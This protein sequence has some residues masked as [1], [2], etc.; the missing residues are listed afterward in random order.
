MTADPMT[1]PSPTPRRRGTLLVVDD[2]REILTALEDLFEED[3]HVHA[4]SSGAEGLDLLH[5][6]P[7]VNGVLDACRE[8]GIT[9]IAYQPLA[10]GVLTGKY[11][12]GEEH[13]LHAD[14]GRYLEARAS[15]QALTL[16]PE[17]AL[18]LFVAP[19][20][21][22]AG[23]RVVAPFMRGYAPSSLPRAHGEPTSLG[24]AVTLLLRP[25]RCTLP[26]GWIGGR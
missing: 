16:D 3:F 25:F 22:D 12:P 11:R 2:E 24:A 7:E 9:L 5:R 13:Q 23:W 17:L 4:A 10:Q 20:L 6:V 19:V 1:Q 18:T 26:I 14:I 8:L 21:V 15:A